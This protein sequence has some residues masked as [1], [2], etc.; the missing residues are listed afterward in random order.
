LAFPHIHN[1]LSFFKGA[2]IHRHPQ[3]I[4]IQ[5]SADNTVKI[6]MLGK[7]T[8]PVQIE[9]TGQLQEISI[10]FK[11]LGLNR[12]FRES[13]HSMAKNISQALSNPTWHSFGASLFTGNNDMERLEKFLLSQYEENTEVERL[14]TYLNALVD[15]NEEKSMSALAKEFG[16]SVKTLQRHFQKHIGCSPIEYKRISRF[17]NSVASKLNEHQLK[18]LTDITYENGY[19]DQSYFIREFKKLTGHNPGKFFRVTT[20]MDG[21][22]L[23]WEM[24]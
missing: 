1:G 24:K 6:E 7:Y 18:K 13:Y 8:Y 11:P 15:L 19:F 21:E 17:R 20:K 16:Y 9:Y 22:S 23:I 10:V 2:S 12:F 14:E 3:K 5:E 4:E